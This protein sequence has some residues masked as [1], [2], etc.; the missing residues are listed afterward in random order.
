MHRIT[1]GIGQHTH[2]SDDG[3]ATWVESL[4]EIPG[5][6]APIVR[7]TV[8]LTRLPSRPR[9]TVWDLVS[10]L[11]HGFGVAV[12]HEATGANASR[13]SEPSTLANVFRTHDG[14]QTWHEHELKVKWRLTGLLRRAAMSWPVEEFTSLVL[15]QPDTVV[16]SWED[17]WIYDGAR[18]HVIYSHDRGELW[19][20]RCLGHTN[21]Y[22]VADY[23]GSLLALNDGF[24]LE[25]V[26]AG[27]KWAKR[28]FAVE[29]PPGVQREKVNLLRHAVFVELNIA[30]ALLVHW[31]RGASHAPAHVGLLHTSDNGTHWRHVHVFDGPDVGDV[32]ERHMLTLQVECSPPAN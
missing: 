26:D 29:Q 20:Y 5:K 31:K 7:G 16:L 9:E 23:S 6:H 10:V 15:V 3:G 32:N 8:N 2:H 14:G 21:P 11:P 24:F 25:S 19:R 12:N 28:E 30:L 1:V 4:R 13:Q 18:S 17:P 27:A 22:L